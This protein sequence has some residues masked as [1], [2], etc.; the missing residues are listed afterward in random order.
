[1]LDNPTLVSY[2]L[3]QLSAI[4]Q[5]WLYKKTRPQDILPLQFPSLLHK[6]SLTPPVKASRRLQTL[7]AT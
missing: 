1:M 6:D 2:N 7:T 3:T 4:Q 5:L